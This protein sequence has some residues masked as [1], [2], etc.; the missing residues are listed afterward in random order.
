MIETYDDPTD[1][2][3]E[4][5]I[6]VRLRAP[7]KEL[8]AAVMAERLDYDEQYIDDDGEPF[9]YRFVGRAQIHGRWET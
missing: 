4:W 3:P 2:M 1:D 8:A 9:D 5:V 6:T 7:S